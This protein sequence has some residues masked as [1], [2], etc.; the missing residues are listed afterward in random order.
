MNNLVLLSGVGDT[1]RMKA[2]SWPYLAKKKLI[3]LLVTF[4]LFTL[5]V[6]EARADFIEDILKGV[7]VVVTVGAIGIGANLA[8]T[9]HD[10][11]LAQDMELP[12]KGWAIAETVLTPPQAIIFNGALVGAH[13]SGEIQKSP[14]H[15]FLLLP[16][17]WTSQMATHGIWSLASNKVHPHDL[18][19]VSWAIGVNLAF[20]SGAVGGAIEK[21]LGGS[22]YGI[23]E[24]VAMMP[25]VVVGL[26]KLSV[27]DDEQVAWGAL[28]AWSGVLFLHGLASTVVGFRQADAEEKEREKEERKAKQKTT[29]RVPFRYAFAPT[30]VSDGVQRVPGLMVSGSF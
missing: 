4:L 13:A 1:R 29:F 28:T 15:N 14:G 5:P 8:F 17:I 30:V 2:H 16:A 27:R 3:A 10:A 25:T 6:K 19:G 26:S 9:V 12:T 11:S 7:A 18:Y 23:I 24:M 22:T 21:R 20:T